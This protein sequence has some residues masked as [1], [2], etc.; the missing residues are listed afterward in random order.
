MRRR[1][2][3]TGAAI[4]EVNRI[5][6]AKVK[7]E[8]LKSQLRPVRNFDA[9]PLPTC[10]RCKRTFRTRIELKGHLR[11]NCTTHTAPTAVPPPASSSSSPPPT[12]SDNSFE[13]PPPSSSSSGSSSC[14]TA[15]T[16]AALV[17]ITHISITHIQNTTTDTIPPTPDS[18]GEGQ[19]YTCP[20]C[21]RTFTSHIGLVSHLRI[22]H[23]E[24]GKLVPEAQTYTHRTRLHGPRCPRT[25][26]HCMGLFGHMRIHESGIDRPP[27]SPTTPNPSPIH[28]HLR[29]PPLSQLTSTAP[30]SPS[31]TVHAHSPL[32]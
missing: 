16:P 15:P 18:R 14:P 23:T 1:K 9:Q 11:T 27:D 29:P 13:P 19:D 10:P 26:M 25:Y 17:A 6:A 24:T 20:H 28:H 3:K 8:A 5:A 2:V 21:D 7:R 30:T 32:A 4:Y 22:H 12:N 31:Y